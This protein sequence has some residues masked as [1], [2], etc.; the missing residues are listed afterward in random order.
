LAT[1]APSAVALDPLVLERY[2]H[3][4]RAWF[5][6]E[7]RFR[8]LGNVSGKLVL[9]VGCGT[10]DNAVLL[11]KCGARVTGIDVS[12]GSIDLARRRA[13][14][15]GVS[16]RTDFICAPLELANLENRSFD[17]IWGDGIL[18]H[19]I[20]EL[21]AVLLKLRQVAEERAVFLFSEPVSFLRVVRAARRFIPIRTDATPN[22]RP[23]EPSDLALVRRHIPD[24]KMRLFGLLGRVNRFVVPVGF[25]RASF[26]R[27]ALANA[28]CAA[29]EVL[30]NVPAVRNLGSM[31]VI[32]GHGAPIIASDKPV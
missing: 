21:D 10:G 24:M 29:D 11:A 5:N 22:E 15:M 27:R 3:P 26:V 7:Y 28:T 9:D 2:L 18:H 14:T 19:V 17:V 23:L 30:L 31:A 1:R 12:P 16:E 25:E 20:D 13:D 4:R 32:W 8:L 6:K